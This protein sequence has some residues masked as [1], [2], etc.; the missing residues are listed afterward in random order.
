MLIAF[1]IVAGLLALVFLAAGL[2]K[3]ARPKEVLATS[4]L[5]WVEDFTT[6]P[7]KLIGAAEVLGALG[8]IL[9]PLLNLAPVLSP[10]AAI[11]LA[12]LMIAAVVVHLRRKEQFLPPLV[13]AIL[14]VVAA[15]LGFLT[16]A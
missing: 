1:W 10:I 6:G 5:A 14:S 8:L 15:I 3:V 16:V 2:M 12:V 4:G 7:V 13:L 11:A 9:P